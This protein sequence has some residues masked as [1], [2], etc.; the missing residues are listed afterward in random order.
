MFTTDRITNKTLPK[1]PLS[2]LLCNKEEFK[3]VFEQDHNFSIFL[4]LKSAAGIKEEIVLGGEE[5]N[6]K[7]PRCG[8][9]Y[10]MFT[11]HRTSEVSRLE[12]S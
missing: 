11:T 4:L 1:A 2:Q 12:S 9:Y 3:R 6:A 5:H 8:N 7:K 10:F